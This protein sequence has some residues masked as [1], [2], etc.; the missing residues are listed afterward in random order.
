MNSKLLAYYQFP[1]PTPPAVPYRV[2]FTSYSGCFGSLT[3]MALP[4]EENHCTPPSQAVGQNNGIL[5]D[6]SPI[7]FA[8]ITDGMSQTILASEKAIDTFRALDEGGTF[9]QEYN[10]FGHYV[11]GNLNGTLFTTK[12]PPNSFKFGAVRDG[13]TSTASSYHPGGVNVLMADGSARFVK[14]TIQSWPVD[15]KDSSP[16]GARRNLAGYWEDLPPL[17][18]WQALS[19]R[20]AGE[21]TPSDGF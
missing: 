12:C 4:Q 11:S 19:T 8:S 18:V 2:C 9:P 3:S 17:G 16:L 6:L 1:D 7:R 21:I 13:I 20:S 14:E 5:N 10:R 15:F